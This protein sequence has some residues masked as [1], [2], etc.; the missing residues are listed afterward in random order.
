MF[1]A[2][3]LLLPRDAEAESGVNMA[4]ISVRTT[5]LPDG[6]SWFWSLWTAT[7]ISWANKPL[8]VHEI[9]PYNRRSSG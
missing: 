9:S 7:P 1:G 3:I 6:A 8:Q 5:D 2:P 4:K